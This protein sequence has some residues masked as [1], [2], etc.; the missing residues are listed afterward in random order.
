VIGLD[1]G[2]TAH[3]AGDYHALAVKDGH[4]YAWGNNLSEQLATERL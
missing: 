2:V 1:S 3:T 4:V